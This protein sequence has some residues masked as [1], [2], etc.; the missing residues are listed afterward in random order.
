MHE[1]VGEA[2]D[3]KQF[4]DEQLKILNKF[5]K[6]ID[7]ELSFFTGQEELNVSVNLS[8]HYSI[9]HLEEASLKALTGLSYHVEVTQVYLFRTEHSCHRQG[10]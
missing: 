9:S 3:V 4:T 7:P 10:N 6:R 1:M 2:F 8:C 5:V